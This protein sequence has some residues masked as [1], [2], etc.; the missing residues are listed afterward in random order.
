MSDI[1][2][3]VETEPIIRTRDLRK[4][5]RL[6]QQPHQRLL[7]L[8]GLLPQNKGLFSEHA[9]LDGVDVDIHPGEKVALIG[10]NGAG[11]STFLKVVTRVTEPTSGTLD[12]RGSSHALLQIGTGF[13]PEFTG[14]AN[15]VSYL[16]HLGIAGREARE[17]LEEVVEFAELEEYIDQP[18]KTYSTGMAARLMF[19]SST[20]F[21]PDLLVLDEVLGVGDA[22]FAQ[23]SYDRIR[24]LCSGGRTTVLLVSHDIYSAARI[25][26]RMIWIDK[27]RVLVDGD[28]PSVI[29]AYEDSVRE[30]EEKRLRAKKLRQLVQVEAKAE[31]APV[32]VEIRAL[33]NEPQPCP[34]EFSKLELK[35]DGATFAPIPFD[36][37]P[38]DES[39][40]AHLSREGSA[41]GNVA[42]NEGRP[43]VPFL[44]Y[45]STYHK[46]VAAFRVPV[47]KLNDASRLGCLAEYR[48]DEPCRLAARVHVDAVTVAGRASL[49]ERH[50]ELGPLPDST[51]DWITHLCCEEAAGS[52]TGPDVNVRGRHGTGR[53]TISDVRTRNAAGE[54]TFFLQH[55]EAVEF[56]I[57]YRINDPELNERCDVVFALQR[58]GVLDVARFR[59]ADLR[60]DASRQST[61]TVRARFDSLPVGNGTY[62]V[63]TM[64]CRE[65]YWDEK[66]N[67]YFAINPGVYTCMSRVIEI[68]ISGGDPLADGTGAILLPAWEFVRDESRESSVPTERVA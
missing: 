11:K 25:C 51:G 63:T 39:R 3:P 64:L 14:R 54:E 41:W 34:V 42:E 58:D 47:E 6:Y 22:Y 66:Q 55:G 53:I 27:G 49:S 59:S 18:L 48:S 30:Q 1:T 10:R 45:G 21:Q 61:G 35:I 20:V 43:A 31:S 57:D 36:A 17:K 29:K 56:E 44:N 15:V 50:V 8:F 16:A 62:T 5:Y 37:D 12:I 33:Q 65:G 28:S 23:K 67:Q 24:E 46:V 4:V 2:T 60:F 9:A 68:T 32:L 52:G 7:D 38:F 26:D 40:P 13:H 19:A